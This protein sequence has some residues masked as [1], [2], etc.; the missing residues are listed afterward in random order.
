MKDCNRIV[1]PMEPRLELSKKSKVSAVDAIEYIAAT[2]AVCQSVWLE[3]LHGD[4]MDQGPKR[5]VL[6]VDG[7]STTFLC[8]EPV[9]RD[10]SKHIDTVYHYI[11]DCVEEGKTKVNY[12]C[13]E[14]Q[15]ADIVTKTLDREKFLKMRRRIGVG[16]VT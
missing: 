12:T 9:R 11:K 15:L 5:V 8:E 1:A 13:T 7:K 6:N 16:A 2:T 14:D 4:L 10:R 3:R